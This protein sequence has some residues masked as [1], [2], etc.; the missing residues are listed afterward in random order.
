MRDC[1][2]LRVSESDWGVLPYTPDFQ[3]FT[4]SLD[5][6]GTGP[7]TTAQSRSKFMPTL[8]EI[9]AYMYLLSAFK[10]DSSSKMK[11]ACLSSLEKDKKA[12]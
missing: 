1:A 9:A 2:A 7:R 3:Q 11:W 5:N 12:P 8:S 4:E 6:Q 10:S